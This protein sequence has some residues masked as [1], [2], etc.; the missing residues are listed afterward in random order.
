[1]RKGITPLHV[2][3]P[4][5]CEAYPEAAIR[6]GADELTVRADEV[7]TL[8][9]TIKIEFD[10]WEPPLADANWHT[11]C[12][13]MYKGI[14]GEEWEELHCHYRDLSKA[15]RERKSRVIVKKRPFWAMKAAKDRIEFY[16]PARKNNILG[17][18]QTRPGVVGRAPRRPNHSLGQS[19][20]VLS[21]LRLA[22][23]S[24]RLV[25]SRLD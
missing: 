17:R 5:F 4:K 23:G 22:I 21:I 18:K 25:E 11:F 1:M 9:A 20:G 12:Q 6:E 13:G 24:K 14:E 8:R 3:K 15:T 7:E 2:R 19:S 10:R 16:D